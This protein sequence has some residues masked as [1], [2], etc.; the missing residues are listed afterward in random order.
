MLQQEH[1]RSLEERTSQV[2]GLKKQLQDCQ[3][4]HAATESFVVSI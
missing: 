4:L 2:D 1:M 3:A